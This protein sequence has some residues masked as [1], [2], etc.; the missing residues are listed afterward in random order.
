MPEIKQSYQ[1]TDISLDNVYQESLQILIHLGASGIKENTTNPT[2]K[3][4]KAV[5]PSIWGWGGMNIAIHLEE[6]PN[7][8]S[9]VLNGYIAQLSTG[10]LTKKMDEFLQQLQSVLKEKYNY[11]FEYEKLTRFLP[12]YKLSINNKD[13]KVFLA[14]IIITFFIALLGV[15]QGFMNE[16]LITGIVVLAGY[17]LGKKYLAD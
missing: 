8:V 14:I 4:I 16:A 1:I 11:S 13:K 6:L 5:I 7:N 17:A 2:A 3:E 12:K 9:L 15:F 10:P